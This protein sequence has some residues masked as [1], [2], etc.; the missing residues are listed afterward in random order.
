[1]FKQSLTAALSAILLSASAQATDLSYTNLSIGYTSNDIGGESYD[2]YNIAIR[3]ALGDEF[4]LHARTSS[5]ESNDAI[6]L[7]GGVPAT[8]D[9]DTTVLGVGYHVEIATQLD[10]VATLGYMDEEQVQGNALIDAD[11]FQVTTGVRWK[12]S[13]MVELNADV[14]HVSLDERTSGGVGI[15][16]RFFF[17]QAVS[18]GTAYSKDWNGAKDEQIS[19]DLRLDF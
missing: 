4:F 15:G 19:A 11:G 3:Y 16:A 18:F 17:G 9:A 1:M 10:F 12:A 7:N 2:G 13:D 8:Q 6:S 5:L 14:L